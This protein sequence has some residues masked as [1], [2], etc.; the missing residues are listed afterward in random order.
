[1]EQLT[2]PIEETS[3]DIDINTSEGLRAFLRYTEDAYSEILE[4]A[5]THVTENT[6]DTLARSSELYDALK[7]NLDKAFQIKEE[8]GHVDE[9]L[10]EAL[11]N[12]YNDILEILDGL[13]TG[14]PAEIEEPEATPTPEPELVV[15]DESSMENVAEAVKEALKQAETESETIEE[16]PTDTAPITEEMVETVATA[17]VETP[18]VLTVSSVET[19]VPSI[20][21]VSETSSEELPITES[22]IEKIDSEVRGTF[23]DEKE[24]VAPSVT[25]SS[26]GELIINEGDEVETVQF[27]E[28]KEK[29]ETLVERAEELLEKY[30]EIHEV[31]SPDAVLNIGQHYYRQL[32]ATAERAKATLTSI[33]TKLEKNDK[34]TEL[35]EE[36]IEDAL[37]EIHENL[38]QLDKGLSGFFETEMS[39]EQVSENAKVSS[40]TLEVVKTEEAEAKPVPIVVIKKPE[41]VP[42]APKPS[43]KPAAIYNET[44]RPTVERKE[45]V[46]K[47][48]W[49]AIIEKVLGIP[50]YKNFVSYTFT[51]P[52]Q[53]EAMVRREINRIEAPS[54]FDSVFGFTNKSAFHDFLRDM[55]IK[56]VAE[57]DALPREQIR[58]ELM[59]KD[60]K[61]EVYLDW[62]DSLNSMLTI[63]HAHPNLTFGEVFIRAE[64]ET[65]IQHE[66]LLAA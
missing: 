60:I 22:K 17:E 39:D 29:A 40:G 43:V 3:E 11:Q 6:H 24:I 45:K 4:S 65:L 5:K 8:G 49:G 15:A 55:T 33:S 44:I 48:E 10:T 9:T 2:T 63:T 59:Q 54:K 34:I 23:D 64:L 42:P 62:V 46:L 25:S 27:S 36:H 38:T 18:K 50:R 37:D 7:A 21:S 20:D 1:M 28:Q 51:S 53:F 13:E 66:E 52:A 14:A 30:K 32:V 26:E 47:G 57:F 19:P 12:G 58:N 31:T 35:V 16:K 41:P 56:E 61:Y